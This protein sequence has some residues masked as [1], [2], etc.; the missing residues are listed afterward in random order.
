NESPGLR[1]PV[2]GVL[3]FPQRVSPPLMTPTPSDEAP[4]PERTQA[5]DGSEI[6]EMEIPTFIRRQMD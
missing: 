3:K 2:P 6:S 1:N 5:K 4:S